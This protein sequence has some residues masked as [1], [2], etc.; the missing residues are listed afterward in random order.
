ML[1]IA[2]GLASGCA[3]GV[4][5]FLGGLKSRRMAAL[6]VVL[7][8]QLSGLALIGTVVAVRGESPPG[9]D[10][11]VFAALAGISGAVALAA[12]YRG[13]ALG[14]MGV[15]APISATAAAIPVTVGIATGDR[16]SAIQG[17][18]LALAIAG[19][20]LA[21]REAGD[22]A[23]GGG[24][25][26]R[27]VGLALMSALGFGLFFVFMDRAAE[28]DALWATFV[29]RAVST[30]A[31]CAAVLA[32]RP[33][34]LPGRADLPTLCLIGV[35]DVSANLMYALASNEGLVSVVAVLGSLYPVTTTLLASVVLKERVHRVQRLGA[36]GALT[37]VAFIAAG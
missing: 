23:G 15:V 27:G 25:L 11:V 18:G 12:F 20:A 24:P 21:S 6:L 1:A 2:L 4:A 13:L 17:V 22:E 29:N 30:T 33:A 34:G 9:G 10:F 28:P 26:S 37:G 35:L 3:W 36:A 5:D 7:A 14:A 16:P 31:L 8:S 32:L 19:V